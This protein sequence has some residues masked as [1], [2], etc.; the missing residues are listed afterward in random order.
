MI[1]RQRV[2]GIRKIQWIR[3]NLGVALVVEKNGRKVN[4]RGEQDRRREKLD[5][6]ETPWM[7]K[8]FAGN[9][10][11]GWKMAEG[12]IPTVTCGLARRSMRNRSCWM[13]GDLR[14]KPI[15]PDWFAMLIPLRPSGFSCSR[16]ELPLLRH[17]WLLIC[18]RMTDYF[19]RAHVCGIEPSRLLVKHLH[20][21]SRMR[22]FNFAR[23]SRF[24]NFAVGLA[25]R[26][27]PAPRYSCPDRLAV[28][29]LLLPNSPRCNRH[30]RFTSSPSSSLPLVHLAS[31]RARVLDTATLAPPEITVA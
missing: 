26:V 9:G 1:F 16:V 5:D 8:E 27:E 6:D 29:Q 24:Y 13:F 31:E 19:A 25:L 21:H 30:P 10:C 11:R 3:A 7:T 20:S 17:S 4:S 28:V 2:A 14:K 23:T 12:I 18:S 22:R 15:G